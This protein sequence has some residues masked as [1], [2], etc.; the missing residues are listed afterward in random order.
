MGISWFCVK[1][2]VHGV[3][4][5]SF[6]SGSQASRPNPRVAAGWSRPLLEFL[7]RRESSIRVLREGP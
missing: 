4:G 1:G 7:L 2:R 3:D 6:G 5:N